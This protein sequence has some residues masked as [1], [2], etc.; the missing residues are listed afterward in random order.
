[1]SEI[2]L[3]ARVVRAERDYFA[4]I[5]CPVDVSP[6]NIY[7]PGC[8]VQLT[9]SDDHVSADVN[10]QAKSIPRDS[11][12]RDEFFNFPPIVDAALITVIDVC[13]ADY[14]RIL[15]RPDYDG[16]TVNAD[17][18]AKP[19]VIAS[20]GRFD[21]LDQSPVIGAALILFIDICR[22]LIHIPSD[23]VII[24]Y[25]A[26]NQRIAIQ[27]NVDPEVIA[28]RVVFRRERKKLAPIVS[29]ALIAVINVDRS[30]IRA[31][32]VVVRCAD[33]SKISDDNDLP[34]KNVAAERIACM[35]FNYM[36]GQDGGICYSVRLD[37]EDNDHTLDK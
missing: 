24:E 23:L 15:L 31:I 7:R 13:S 8:V 6:V 36:R 27:G 28:S 16:I 19:L 33:K 37:K 1:M 3:G 12:V 32:A 30:G 20:V 10:F 18:T 9:S 5:I 34:A 35:Q 11:V 17:G 26:H 14:G 2:H 22:A 25:C 4:P 29:S 21:L